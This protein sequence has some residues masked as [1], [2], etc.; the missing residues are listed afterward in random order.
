M[1]NA[2][3]V[4]AKAVVNAAKDVANVA[5]VANPMRSALKAT[6]RPWPKGPWQR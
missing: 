4:G 5:S 2:L 6:T 1:A 3:K